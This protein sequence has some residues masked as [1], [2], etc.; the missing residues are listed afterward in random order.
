M[1]EEE[2]TV[3]AEPEKDG[4]ESTGEEDSET[5]RK[6]TVSLYLYTRHLY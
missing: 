1:T 2:V 3:D 5:P 4:E 6:L